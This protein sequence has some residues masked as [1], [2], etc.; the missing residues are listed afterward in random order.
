MAKNR[1]FASII[2]SESEAMISYMPLKTKRVSDLNITLAEK[3]RAKEDNPMFIETIENG[4]TKYSNAILDV[5]KPSGPMNIFV[6]R[7][8]TFQ[9]TNTLPDYF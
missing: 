5:E 7:N 9:F 3:I 8:K 4:L 6:E 2:G 1:D